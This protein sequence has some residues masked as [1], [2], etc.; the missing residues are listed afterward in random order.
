MRRFDW[1]IVTMLPFAFA[2]VLAMAQDTGTN[3]TD[4]NDTGNTSDTFPINPEAQSVED[5]LLRSIRAGDAIFD[6]SWSASFDIVVPYS[7]LGPDAG[8]HTK[9]CRY[10]TDQAVQ[11]LRMDIVYHQ[12]PRY[13]PKG[14]RGVRT[15]RYEEEENL[16]LWRRLRKW[17]LIG[18]H[19]NISYWNRQQLVIDPRNVIIG[20]TTND[21]VDYFPVGDTTSIYELLEFRFASGRGFADSIKRIVSVE[22]LPDGS[23]EVVA[24]AEEYTRAGEWRLRVAPVEDYGLV[25]EAAFSF[26]NADQASVLVETKG[27]WRRDDIVLAQE[28]TVTY[29]FFDRPYPLRITIKNFVPHVDTE[30]LD[31]VRAVVLAP[32]PEKGFQ[33]TIGG[34]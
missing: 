3:P 33:S 21:C 9:I 4:D 6:G 18:A 10:T 29:H 11:A 16:V 5:V 27:V 13:L 2:S 8:V 31:E 34:R 32:V 17:S 15:F 30:L 28:G 7:V 26:A 23:Q 25:R 1:A 22:S 12:R 20:D 14:Q 24:E 19:L